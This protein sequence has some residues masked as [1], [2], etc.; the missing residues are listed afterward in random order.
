MGGVPCAKVI[1]DGRLRAKLAYMIEIT[2]VTDWLLLS[3]SF[4]ETE[5]LKEI[6]DIEEGFCELL[7]QYITKI[8]N[9]NSK[10]AEEI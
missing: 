3:N 1:I 9:L 2:R 6:I 8:T 4:G 5:T 10:F 7:D